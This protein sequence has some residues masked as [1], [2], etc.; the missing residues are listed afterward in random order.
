MTRSILTILANKYKVEGLSYLV[1]RLESRLEA[2]LT[3]IQNS[4]DSDDTSRYLEQVSSVYAIISGLVRRPSGTQARGLIQ[5]LRDVPK[6]AT[7]GHLL[8]RRL[9]MLV[10]PQKFLS[11]DSFAIVKPL[12][13]QKIYFELVKP[14]LEMTTSQDAEVESQLIKTNFRIGVLSMVRHMPFSIWEDDSAEIL[15]ASMALSQNL[16]PGPDT[17]PALEILKTILAESS[18]KAQD[19][20]KS[21]INIALPC[22]SAKA[23]LAQKRPDWLP[24]GYVPAK[25]HPDIEAEC[26]KLALEVVG[27]LP[28]LFESRYVVPFVPQVRRELSLACGHPV[29]DLRRLARIARAAWTEIK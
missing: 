10:A 3:N 25:I 14:M 8:A 9:E 13:T 12:W 20:I 27:A 1:T 2:A 28:R 17:L 5:R 18:D 16:G 6:N 11:K 15:R 4:S 23:A 7:A 29:R 24:S 19:Y 22:F 21:L 26:G